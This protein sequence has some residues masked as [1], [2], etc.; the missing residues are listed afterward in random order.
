MERLQLLR[1]YMVIHGAERGGCMGD[2]VG[3]LRS[4]DRA[5]DQRKDG[6]ETGKWW[7][8]RGIMTV[9]ETES[10]CD[11]RFGPNVLS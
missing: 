2:G 5:E 6:V 8:R 9:C 10:K 1:F 11:Q 3:T 4:D 7:E